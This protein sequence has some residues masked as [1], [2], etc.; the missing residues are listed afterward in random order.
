MGDITADVTPIGEVSTY[1]ILLKGGTRSI[2]FVWRFCPTY[3]LYDQFTLP[4][5]HQK[6]KGQ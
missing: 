1:I 6:R 2:S 4:P 5:R 3:F